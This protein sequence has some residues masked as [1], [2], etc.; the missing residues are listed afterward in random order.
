MSTIS[1]RPAKPHATRVNRIIRSTVS[2]V[3]HY[4]PSPTLMAPLAQILAHS[5]TSKT[6]LMV[7]VIDAHLSVKHVQMPLNVSHVTETDY[8][9][10]NMRV[11]A[12]HDAPVGS[13]ICKEYALSAMT[14]VLN[15]NK[16]EVPRYARHAARDNS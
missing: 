9:S 12:S 14:T 7:S 3:T 4:L 16:E 2:L 11:D 15:V 8:K 1:V 6:L 10:L 13:Q 5:V